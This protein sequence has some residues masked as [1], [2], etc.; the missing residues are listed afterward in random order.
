MADEKQT[1]D[2]SK[3]SPLEL[4]NPTTGASVSDAIGDGFYHLRLPDDAT[5]SEIA[6]VFNLLEI[7][8]GGRLPAKLRDAGMGRFLVALNPNQKEG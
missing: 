3:D 8:V 1:F 2:V 5:T 7:S 4:F 6:A